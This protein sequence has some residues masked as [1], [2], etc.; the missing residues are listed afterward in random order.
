MYEL[1]LTKG[2]HSMKNS[3]RVF[4]D[5]N[6]LITAFFAISVAVIVAYI[7]SMDLREWFNGAGDWFNLLFQLAVGYIINFMFY[8][9]QVY[10][11]S[12]KRNAIVQT[13]IKKRIS[14]LIADMDK[15]LL[16]L[17]DIYTENHTG[18]DY[19]EDELK[20]LLHKLRFSDE[21]NVIDARK[22]RGANFVHFTVRD[23]LA[24]CIFETERDIDNL[25]KYYAADI[26]VELMEILEKIPRSTYHSVMRTL[27]A[28]QDDVDF[29]GA[30]SDPKSNF[31][32]EYYNLIQELRQK[33][34]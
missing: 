10:V 2:V 28:A 6:K 5:K 4:I 23:W 29:S 15:S 30:A 13:C 12:S 7:L 33:N 31:F 1:L 26:P 19:T 20:Q 24:N 16:H 22:T 32:V 3:I 25:F 11:P 17:A 9:T 14:L 8:V 27:L 18:P 21:V 34:N